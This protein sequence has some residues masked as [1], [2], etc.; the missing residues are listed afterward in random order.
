MAVS[1]GEPLCIWM[2][3]S[4]REVEGSHKGDA[5]SDAGRRLSMVKNIK[6][7]ART[8]HLMRIALPL[9]DAREDETTRVLKRVSAHGARPTIVMP[10]HPDGDVMRRQ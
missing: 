10:R 4:A 2:L 8:R 9:G 7:F 1:G 5:L 3:H 6:P